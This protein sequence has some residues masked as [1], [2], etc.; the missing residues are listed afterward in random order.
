MS[1]STGTHLCKFERSFAS[2]DI[3]IVNVHG[4][5]LHSFIRPSFGS[6]QIYRRRNEG[7]RRAYT[8]ACLSIPASKPM[9]DFPRS[10]PRTFP[11]ARC[12]A[13]SPVMLVQTL[14]LRRARRSSPGLRT[15]VSRWKNACGICARNMYRPVH[16]NSRQFY[17]LTI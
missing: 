2:Y 14:D 8:C 9:G 12:G 11:T 6:I 1:Y 4:E 10:S 13:R 3:F 15:E 17:R 16:C 7:T 5:D